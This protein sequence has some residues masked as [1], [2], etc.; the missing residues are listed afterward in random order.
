MLLEKSFLLRLSGPPENLW[1]PE[2]VFA[3]KPPFGALSRRGSLVEG[4]LLAEVPLLGQIQLPFRS[5]IEAQGP[6]ARLVALPLPEPLQFW[7]ELAGEGQAVEDG[8]VYRLVL[9]VHAKLPEGEKWGGRALRR[10]A[11]VAFDRSVERVLQRLAE[12]G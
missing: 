8:L 1:A 2:R 9:R 7:A 11:E 4:Y 3:G 12:G 6:V 5:R 10:M